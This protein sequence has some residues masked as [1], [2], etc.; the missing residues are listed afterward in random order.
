M[1]G[2]RVKHCGWLAIIVGLFLHAGPL[3]A[4]EAVPVI[5]VAANLRPAMEEIAQVFEKRSGLKLRFSFGAS[6]NLTRQI[7]QGAP[8]QMFMSADEDYVLRL[9]E[10]GKTLDRGSVYA[11]GRI[12]AFTP[13]GSPLRG[14]AFPGGYG[15]VL[16]GEGGL[17]YAIANPKLAPYGRAAKEALSHAGLWPRLKGRLIVGESIAQT[18]QFSL[19]GSALGGIVAYSQALSPAF[20]EGGAH[21]L[22]PADWHAPLG[23]RMAL[24][25]GAGETSR[26]FYDFILGGGADAILQKNGYTLP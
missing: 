4:A 2:R 13:H 16:D 18:A 10:A 19:S 15:D 25:A 14:R 21:H 26:R 9:F 17:R 24:I 8:F 1:N 22:I 12:A 7:L 11:F 3:R 23:Q 5:A 6:G 20:A